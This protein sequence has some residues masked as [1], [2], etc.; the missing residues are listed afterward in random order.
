MF[1]TKAFFKFYQVIG[2]IFPETPPALPASWPF[3]HL[4]S[5]NTHRH[6]EQKIHTDIMNRETH[7]YIVWWTTVAKGFN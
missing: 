6:N 1:S 3:Q 4:F 7:P 5:E 2:D